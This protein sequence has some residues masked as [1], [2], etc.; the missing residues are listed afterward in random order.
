[1]NGPYMSEQSSSGHQWSDFVVFTFLHARCGDR[2]IETRLDECNIAS[3]CRH[4]DEIRIFEAG[5]D[6]GK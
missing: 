3:W 4:C 5:L 2:V 6:G 1:M